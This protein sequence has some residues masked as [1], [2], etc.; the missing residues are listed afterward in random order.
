MA[1]LGRATLVTP[2]LSTGRAGRW[3]K[4]SVDG[5]PAGASKTALGDD[6]D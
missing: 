1:F 4:E 3:F 5:R 6:E 2:I